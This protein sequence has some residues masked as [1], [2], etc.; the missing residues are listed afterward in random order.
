M[1]NVVQRIDLYRDLFADA[2]YAVHGLALVDFTLPAMMPAA[3][4]L[5]ISP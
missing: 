3:S 4:L 5:L 1:T 2:W